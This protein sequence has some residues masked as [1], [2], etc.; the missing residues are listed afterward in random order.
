MAI[1]EGKLEAFLGQIVVDAGA[2]FSTVLVDIGERL[3]VYRAL[4]EGGAQTSTELAK[5]TGVGERLLRELLYNQAAGGYVGY[6]A[7]TQTFSL[8]EEQAFVLAD[9]DSPVAIRG[10]IDILSSAYADADKLVDAFRSGKG[11]HWHEHDARLFVGTERFFRPGYR[12]FLISDWI[13]SLDGVEE[14]LRAGAKVADVGCGHGVSTILMAEAYPQSRF[15]GWDYHAPSI[16]AARK[17]AADAGVSDRVT[18]EVGRAQN[19]DGSDY[20]LICLFDCLHD[21]GDFEGAAK[22]AKSALAP[23]GTLLL[24]EPNGQDQPED[25]FNPVGRM[26]YAASATICTA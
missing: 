13:P 3:G 2:A 18:F 16:E 19:Y 25:N 17:A 5:R 15:E 4:A 8:S 20:D 26:F 9:P 12:Q 21:M 22:H 10:L 24:V 14:K 11:M 6:D 1:D 7:K 23:G